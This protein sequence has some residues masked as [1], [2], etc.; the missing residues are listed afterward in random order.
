MLLE[1][2]IARAMAFSFKDKNFPTS[3]RKVERNRYEIIF[4]SSADPTIKR[5]GRK[6]GGHANWMKKLLKKR[7]HYPLRQES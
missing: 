7:L 4:V 3:C 1:K 5:I 2:V 6:K